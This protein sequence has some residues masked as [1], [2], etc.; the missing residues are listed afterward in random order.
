MPYFCNNLTKLTIFVYYYYLYGL[1]IKSY[2]ILQIET[3]IF[4]EEHEKVLATTLAFGLTL[5]ISAPAFAAENNQTNT[6][7]TPTS[8]VKLK[9]QMLKSDSGDQSEQDNVTAKTGFTFEAGDTPSATD[10]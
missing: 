5:S 2:Q 8:E 6:P 10:F 4:Y 3:R 9:S 1:I 7:T